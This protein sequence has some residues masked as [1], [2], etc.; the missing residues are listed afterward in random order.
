M[1]FLPPAPTLN[2]CR[3]VSDRWVNLWLPENFVE[4]FTPVSATRRLQETESAS[5]CDLASTGSGDIGAIV[6]VGNLVLFAGVLL[7]IFLL[8]VLLASGV[9][10]YWLT[11][12]ILTVCDPL[13][14]HG[15]PPYMI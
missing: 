13:L 10:A 12:V 3:P 9:E 11:K 14:V 6:F 15:I 4:T 7:A 1:P 8:H 2:V 5:R